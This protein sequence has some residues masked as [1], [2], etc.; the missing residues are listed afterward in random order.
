MGV[1]GTDHARLH[2][3]RA[4]VPVANRIGDEGDGLAVAFGGFL[5]PSRISV[6]MSCVGL[7]RRAAELA[8]EY[9]GK[10]ETFGK[11]LDQRQAIPS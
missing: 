6:A 1:R 5:T 9:A 2:F 8:I 4:P 7:A 10:R 11:T 3:D